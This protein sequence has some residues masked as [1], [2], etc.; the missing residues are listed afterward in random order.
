MLGKHECDKCY[1][2]YGGTNGD[3]VDCQRRSAGQAI[4]QRE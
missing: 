2:V 1:D 3:H 4:Y